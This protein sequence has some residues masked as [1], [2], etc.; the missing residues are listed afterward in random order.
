MKI[1][2]NI[3]SITL[4][5]I[6]ILLV[7]L[8]LFFR[9][10]IPASYIPIDFFA[11]NDKM[12]SYSRAKE[13]GQITIG[14]FAKIRTRFR[15]NNMGWNYPI[16]YYPVNGKEL[17]AVIGDSYI[18]AFQVNVDKNYPFL[19]R[20]QL[21]NKYEVYAFGKSGAPLSQYLN[22][23]RYVNKYFNPDILIFNLVHNDFDESIQELNGINNKFLKVSINEAGTITET[24]PQPDY[25]TQQ[26]R[27]FKRF[28]YKSA[29]VRYLYLNL[30]IN[31][32]LQRISNPH[33]NSP[34]DTYEANIN[35]ADVKKNK[36]LIIKVTNYLLSTIREENPDKRIIFMF[37]APR[38]N[39]YNNTLDRSN[40]LWMNE[41]M[42]TIC[43]KHNIEYID[44]TPLMQKDYQINNT[45]FNSDIDFHW[46][47]YGHKL[48]ANILYE[49]LE[50]N[51]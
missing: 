28:I 9:F 2:K 33:A 18:E 7:V 51:N 23:S 27:P 24:T 49:Y 50:R 35:T 31:G 5:T 32:T 6:L 8:E 47:E 36:E 16:D 30:H 17:I 26:Y 21:K 38:A 20:D 13:K 15:I 42:D 12:V 1:V 11:E 46:N 37:D 22:I 41:M 29:I 3:I 25:S 4:P 45:K 14:K 19:L 34:L 39:I 43:A 10:V 44:L 48:I 40:V